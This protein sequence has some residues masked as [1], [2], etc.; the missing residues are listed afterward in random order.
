MENAGSQ[1]HLT[2]VVLHVHVMLVHEL[3]QSDFNLSLIKKSLLVLDDLN[4]HPLLFCSVICFNNLCKKQRPKADYQMQRGKRLLKGFSPFSVGEYQAL[5]ISA[6]LGTIF[7]NTEIQ[8]SNQPQP[9]I[10]TATEKRFPSSLWDLSQNSD[11]F[12]RI[13]WLISNPPPHS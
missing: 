5:Q 13:L 6:A 2:Y 9:A 10:K 1:S 11:V 7:F 8:D 12:L 4:C 3:Q